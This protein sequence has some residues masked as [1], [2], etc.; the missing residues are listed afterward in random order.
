MPIRRGE[1]WG[2][3]IARPHGAAVVASDAELADRSDRSGPVIVAG[4]DL[5]RS[6]GG[7]VDRDPVQLLPVDLLDLT[8]DGERY[9]AA[10]HVVARGSWW[11]GPIVAVLNVGTVGEWDVAPRAHPNDGR[12]DVIE[13][14]PAMSI[15]QRWQARSRLPLGSHVPHPAIDVRSVREGSWTFD[16]PLRVWIDGRPVG[17]ARSIGA[18]VRP[19]AMTVAA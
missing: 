11:R 8:V 17:R 12:M 10:A 9:V 3:E 15:R 4:G 1:P 2:R 13:V 18:R 14:D 19:D 6:L 7:P 16:R 5:W